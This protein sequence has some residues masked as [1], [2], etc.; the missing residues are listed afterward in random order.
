MNGNKVNEKPSFLIYRSPGGKV[1]V[2]RFYN[3]QGVK[4]WLNCGKESFEELMGIIREN[5]DTER[6]LYHQIIDIYAHSSV[7]YDP[8]SEETKDFYRDMQNSLHWAV[9]GMTAADIIARRA[10]ADKPFMGLTSWKN[11]PEGNIR[12]SDVLVAKNYLKAKE[13]LELNRLAGMFLHF[14]E[15]QLEWNVPLK[16]NDWKTMLTS[17]LRV[18]EYSILPENEEITIDTARHIAELEYERF[19]ENRSSW[20]PEEFNREMIDLLSLP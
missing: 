8:R 18:Y 5:R 14:A 12:K 4:S 15:G 1:Q 20:F 13:V 9:T 10:D 7:D 3:V 16:L 11:A 19:K 2:H 6:G 17:F